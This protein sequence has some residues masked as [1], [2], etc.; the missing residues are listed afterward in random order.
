M[1]PAQIETAARRKYNSS[2]SSFYSSNEIYDLIYQ[3]ELEAAEQCKV[4]E[5]LST[6]TST[7]AGTQSYA[8]PTNAFEIKRV[9]YNGAKL[10]PI[11]M[12]QDDS[13][14]L[15]NSNTT[16]QGTPSHYWIWNDTIYLRPIPDAV[17]TLKIYS[18]NRPAAVTSASQT[19]EIPVL[20][21]MCIVDFVVAEMMLKDGEAALAQVYLNRWYDR[22]LPRMEKWVARRK[23]GDR[24]NVVKNV[25]ELIGTNI[26]AI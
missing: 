18:Y 13:L 4:I 25:D 15:L 6:A 2:S 10:K 5:G 9:E 24:F 20:F 17:Q 23:R 16:A 12:T 22:H 8:F 19:L 11:D 3:A 14:T 7:V 26:G 1:T 21:H